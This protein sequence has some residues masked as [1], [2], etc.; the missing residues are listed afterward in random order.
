MSSQITQSFNI[1]IVDDHQLFR[2]GVIYALKQFKSIKE[3]YEAENG[4]EAVKLL[5]KIDCDIVFMDIIM[6]V[7]DGINAARHIVKE[8][9]DV[10]VIALSM[11]DDETNIT[12]MIEA[13]ASGYL[14]KNTDGKEMME[15]IT[16]VYAGN[17]Y[18]SDKVSAK[19]HSHLMAKRN[20]R[21]QFLNNNLFNERE[22]VILEL[23]CDEYSSEEIG[24]KLF[25]S[26][27][28]VEGYRKI[29]LRKTMSRNVA[30]LVRFAIREGYCKDGKK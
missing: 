6:P 3:I 28:T 20:E 21:E 2:Q 17:H 13:G 22:L 25:V 4:K 30:G 29:L 5:E 14:V 8:F 12:R 27:R 9:P 26:R 7:M 15:A 24:G 1:L 11:I 23:I 16:K 19:L 18:Y 10:Y